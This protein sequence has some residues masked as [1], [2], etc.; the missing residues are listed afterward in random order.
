M[1]TFKKI[2]LGVVGVIIGGFTIYLGYFGFFKGINNDHNDYFVGLCTL[3]TGILAITGVCF[4]IFNSQRIKNKELLNDLD[5]KSEWRKELMNIASNTYMTTDDIYRVLASLRYTPKIPTE[6]RTEK[7]DFDHMTRIIYDELYKMLKSKYNKLINS[8]IIELQ[9]KNNETYIKKEIF[10]DYED[11]EVI[12]LYTKYLL[13]HH[14]EININRENWEK[15]YQKEVIVEIKKKRN[16]LETKYKPNFK[17]EYF[18]M[19][20]CKVFKKIKGFLKYK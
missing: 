12:R 8:N 16:E 19:L 1:E 20:V 4:T 5:Q 10:L 18:I 7:N 2:F 14:W 13:K 17:L 3:F 9:D 6:N 11:I 15:K